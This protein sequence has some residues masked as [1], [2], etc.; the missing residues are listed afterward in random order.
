MLDWVTTFNGGVLAG[1]AA[2]AVIALIAS[3]GADFGATPAYRTA[4]RARLPF[5]SEAMALSVRHRTRSLLR[6]NM[7]GLLAT[8]IAAS[9]VFAATP[10]SS[11]PQFLWLVTLSIFLVVLTATAVVVNLRERLFH[12]APTAVRVARPR[13]LRVR[14]YVGRGR[15]LTPPV[16]L[17]AATASCAILAVTAA[18]RPVDR[19][20]LVLAYTALGFAVLTAVGG[21]FA[22]RL[23]LAQPQ[24][25][26]DTL[27]LAWDDLFRADALSV[28]R[29][30]AATAAWLPLGCALTLSAD[31][32]LLPGSSDVSALF[33][34]WGIPAIQVLY[35][36]GQGKLPASIYPD[37]LHPATPASEEQFA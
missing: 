16:L 27:E 5:G 11:S 18:L 8:V 13:A 28:L 26:S 32:W 9:V 20:E 36:L 21:R 31:A 6:A 37:F 23:V 35:T 34:W 15:R 25:A 29:M 17:V 30:G 7:W 24:P 14:D 33:P 19:V 1:I 12:P 2:V 10:L 22:E 4:L 3:R